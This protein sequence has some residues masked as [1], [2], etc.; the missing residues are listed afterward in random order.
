MEQNHDL[1]L[2]QMK[3]KWPNNDFQVPI[4]DNY[5]FQIYALVHK[6]Y[7]MTLNIRLNNLIGSTKQK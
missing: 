6:G 7:K 2:V 1:Y 5:D 3:D 4:T